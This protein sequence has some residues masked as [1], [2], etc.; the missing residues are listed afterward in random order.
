MRPSIAVTIAALALAV[1]VPEEA[2]AQQRAP[3]RPASAPARVSAAGS[4][5]GSTEL[6]SRFGTDI[7]ARLMRSADAEERLRGIERAS[8]IHTPE[9]LALLQRAA[10]ASI[11]GAIDPRMPLD[12][13]ARADPRA[14]LVVVRALSAWSERE[15]A[16]TA[17]A[18]IV[19]GPTQSFATRVAT[20][21]T[22]DPTAEDAEG[23]AQVLLARQEAATV[24]AESGN[25]FALEALIAIARSAGPG[26]APAL[27]ALAIHPPAAPL[28]GG[29]V[30]T[31]PA[32]VALAA[33]IGD[34]RSLDAIA[35][36]MSASDPA[37]R[38]AALVALGGAG[39]AR[40]V[41]A[42]HA[43]LRDHDARVRSAATEA[44]VRLG[45]VDAGQAVEALIGDDATA[46]DGLRLAQFVQ[47]DGVTKAAAARAA[48]SA[49][50]ELRAAAIAALGRQ[51][52]ASAIAALVTLVADP[53]L[54]GDA[55]CAIARSPS[56]AA[57]A[58]IE[59]I[60]RAVPMRRLAARAYLV[61]RLLREDQSS[62][63]DALIGQLAASMDGRDRAMG[64]EALVAFGERSVAGALNDADARV[65][66]AAAM[67]AIV[68]SDPASRAALLARMIAEPD[69][70]TRFVLAVGL[71]DGDADRLTPT[72]DLVDRS[73]S[74]GPDAPLASLA[75]AER[76]DERQASEIDALLESHDP[77]LRLHVAL[78]LAAN[79]SREVVGRLARAYEREGDAEVR[80]AIVTALSL[81]KGKDAAAPVRRDTLALAARL[82][83]DRVVRLT[84]ARALGTA[85]TPA[86]QPSAREVAWVRLTPAEGAELPRNMSAALVQ[87]GG[88]ALP[89]A[90]DDDGYAIVPGVW[91]GEARLRLAPRPP[92]Y[93]AAAP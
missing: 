32:T 71:V 51:T 79:A 80:R 15:Q 67:G 63:L 35:G 11:S 75:L 46:A 70:V 64:T 14:L 69:E 54:Q 88:L 42:A 23:A 39:D 47:S 31:T 86:G 85:A 20:A 1:A 61:R 22:D 24:L 18:S 38:S 16:R 3:G 66:R 58:A 92:A 26:Q 29:V 62:R 68:R 76:A 59:A 93:E 9:A 21:A 2:S 33:T 28:L 36:A 60:A 43:S 41:N 34:L 48:A 6:R 7:A 65:R 72:L 57:I 55:A 25:L 8:A 90:F 82:D 83:P 10:A 56:P 77:V 52:A 74:G 17:L 44:L 40:V 45:A 84:A 27:D 53:V 91:S 30:L 73:R 4:G 49:N 13:V 81:R 19:A 87:S 12:G 5:R 78:G 89:I 37:L 50:A